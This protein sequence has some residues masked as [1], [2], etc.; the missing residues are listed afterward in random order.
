MIWNRCS[1][2][3]FSMSGVEVLTASLP[4]VPTDLKAAIGPAG[5]PERLAALASFVAEE[6]QRGPVYPASSD[7]FRALELTP[8]AEG[9]PGAAVTDATDFAFLVSAISRHSVPPDCEIRARL[10]PAAL[11]EWARECPRR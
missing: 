5:S 1:I 2:G 11:I 6:Q 8:P 10:A 4:A 7:I 9:V 3:T